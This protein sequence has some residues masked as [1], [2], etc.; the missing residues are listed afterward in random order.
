ML[1]YPEI[2]ADSNITMHQILRLIYLDQESPVNSLFFYEQ[3]DK[4]IYR[5]TVANLLLGLY[6]QKYSDAKLEL[7]KVVKAIAEVK[8]SIKNV[9]EFLKGMNV[10]SS[11]ISYMPPSETGVPAHTGGYYEATQRVR[12]IGAR[13]QGTGE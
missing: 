13:S 11:A 10:K 6:D 12:R 5:E 1:G 3:F 2:K 8:V 7:Q 9:S 4:E